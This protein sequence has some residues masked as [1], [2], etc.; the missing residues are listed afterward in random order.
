MKINKKKWLCGVGRRAGG[1]GGL[2]GVVWG[3]TLRSG[4]VWGVTF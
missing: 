2:V 1:G 4:A 3:F